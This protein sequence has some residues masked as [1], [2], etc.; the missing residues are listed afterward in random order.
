MSLI[1]FLQL[2]VTKT[3]LNLKAEARQSYLN[4]IWWLLEPA[5]FVALFYVVFGVFL[6]NGNNSFLLFLLCGQI[7]FMWF[8]RTVGNCSASIEQGKA[9]M[10]QIYIPKMFF[11]LV[12]ICQDTVKSF[13]VFIM[14]FVFIFFYAESPLIYWFSLPLI[15]VV[16]F[17]FVASVSIIGA[18]I[19]PFI[20]DFKYLIATF[21]QMMMFASG[22]FFNYEDLLLPEHH[23][24]FLLNPMAN[25]ITQ[26]RFVLLEGRWPDFYALGHI[27]LFSFVLIIGA[28]LM[29][30]KVDGLYPKILSE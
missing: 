22:V 2:T 17:F 27:L 25:I 21:V 1:Q 14:F 24:L 19:V 8:A 15:L 26:F 7:P 16:Q 6:G 5:L 12:T 18:M 9:L 11:P 29:M 20:P 30:R 23:E 3:K 10:Q 28:I 13:C 4:Y